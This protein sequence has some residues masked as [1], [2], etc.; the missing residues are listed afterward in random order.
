[1]FDEKFTSLQSMSAASVRLSAWYP[2]GTKIKHIAF[3]CGSNEEITLVDDQAQIRIYS[4]ITQQ[5]R[6]VI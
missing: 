3:V 4:L 1:M 2:N 5:F 6:C